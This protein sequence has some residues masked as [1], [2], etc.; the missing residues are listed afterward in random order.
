MSKTDIQKNKN[1]TVVISG[2]TS[3]LGKEMCIEFAK[4]GWLVAGLGKTKA[5]VDEMTRIMGEKHQIKECDVT[6]NESVKSFS[7]K[8]IKKLGVPELLINNA[9]VM[10]APKPLWEVPREEFDYLTHVNINGVANMIR[11]FLPSMVEK[12]QGIIINLSSGWG[13]STSPDVAPY[14][15]TK[16]AIEGLSGALAQELPKGMGCIALNPG[17]I[18]TD[19]LRKCW[20]KGAELYQK[21]RDWA[22]LAVPFIENL[23]YQ[24]NGKQMSAP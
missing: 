11:H 19:M 7:E 23:S 10:N 22:K 6:C 8:I 4:R 2:S 18:D 15:A 24:D 16:W 5:K 17:V 9:A 20:G 21:P 12:R 14:C 13:R 3:G 1:K